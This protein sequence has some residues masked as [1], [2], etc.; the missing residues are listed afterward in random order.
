MML[1]SVAAYGQLFKCVSK[2][3][4]VEYASQ[5]PPGT[6]QQATGIKT[7][8]SSPSSGAEA[9]QKSLAERD[10]EFRKRLTEKDEAQASETKKAAEAE[11]RRRACD[12]ARAYL[13]SLQAGNRVVRVDPKTG[14]R[15]FLEDAGYATEIATAQRSVETNC[16]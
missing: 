7:T 8:P 1:L 4:K 11:Q 15:I 13:K 5:C 2:D 10:A 12:D 9:P 6:K 14:E 3:G 16:K